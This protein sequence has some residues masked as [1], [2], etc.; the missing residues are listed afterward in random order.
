M[1]TTKSNIRGPKFADGE[2][3]FRELTTADLE[4]VTGGFLNAFSEALKAHKAKVVELARSS[5]V[6]GPTSTF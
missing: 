2:K 6:L 4:E 3:V 1:Q 5:G